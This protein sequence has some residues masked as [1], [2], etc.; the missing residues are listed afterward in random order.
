MARFVRRMIEKVFASDF[1]CELGRKNQMRKSRN[2]KAV[3]HFRRPNCSQL[4]II[5]SGMD[6]F[7]LKG[8]I[9]GLG[10]LPF[11][12]ASGLADRNLIWIR[13]PYAD[14][15]LHGLGPEIP[16]IPTLTEWLRQQIAELPRVT[17]VYVIGYSSGS[18]V[19]LQFGHLLGVK[20]VWAFSPRTSRVRTAAVMK[21]ALHDQFSVSNGVTE[22]EIGYADENLPD[23][24]FAEF[25]SDCPGVSVRPYHGYG[26]T[27]F[28]M[29]AMVKDGSF[30]T[31]V[32]PFAGV[33]SD[34]T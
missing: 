21:A 15:L 7:L 16:D 17:E 13:D 33:T 4:F 24:S 9:A 26:S 27:H 2:K 31:V 34:V 29:T 11:L 1:A 12:K 25:M 28:L 14:N 32:P 19:A 30:R 23:R 6:G 18:Y 5:F 10:M 20:K 3:V 22:Y 8:M